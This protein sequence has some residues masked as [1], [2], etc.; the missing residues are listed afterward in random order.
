MTVDLYEDSNNN[1][2]IDSGDHLVGQTTTAPD[3]SYLF[4]NLPAGNYLVD[5]T[6]DAQVL[7]GYWHSL[8][9]AGTDNNSQTDPYPV[10]LA[11]GQNYLAADFGYY[12]DPGAVG[13]RV[14]LDDDGNGIQDA[15]ES[16]IGNVVVKLTITYPNGQTTV[17][18]T[19][20]DGTGYYSFGN[21]LLDED[22]NGAGTYGTEP[23][24]SISVDATQTALAGSPVRHPHQRSRQHG[25]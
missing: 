16:G 9:A 2:I 18:T 13:N 17:L 15:G 23:T 4:P 8:G 14:W 21:L 3:G 20:T 11:A 25:L 5:V 19:L 24:Y 12:V 7:N 22:Y 10:T 6:D 1:G